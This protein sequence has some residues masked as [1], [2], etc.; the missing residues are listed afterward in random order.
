MNDCKHTLTDHEL[1][2]IESSEHIVLEQKQEELWRIKVPGGWLYT[3]DTVFVDRD[4]Q[5]LS[6]H[7][8]TI[9][10]PDKECHLCNGSAPD[11]LEG[12]L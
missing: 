8:N 1:E 5:F 12:S 7:A 3:R 11:V 4:N 9:F 10:V 6:A 2:L